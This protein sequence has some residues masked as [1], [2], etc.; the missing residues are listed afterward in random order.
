VTRDFTVV[1]DIARSGAQRF[2]G[3]I[4]LED[5]SGTRITYCDLWTRVQTRAAALRSLGLT[6]GDCVLLY[7]SSSPSWLTAFLAIVHADLVA[8]PIPAT[9]PV[10]LARLACYYASVRVALCDDSDTAGRLGIHAVLSDALDTEGVEPLETSGSDAGATAV[11]VFTSGSTARPRAVALSHANLL[12]NLRSVNEVR[13]ARDGEALL[14]ILPP[15]H[16]FELVAGQL[17]PLAAG[18]RVVYPRSLL[19]NRLLGYVRDRAIT[20]VLCVPSL[21]ELLS[22][23][24]VLMLAEE[25]LVEARCQ[26]ASAADL[27]ARF[28][29]LEATT[30]EQVR[31]AVRRLVGPAFHGLVVGGAA[32]DRPWVDLLLAAGIDVDL[33]YGLTEAGPIVSVGNARE[34]PS[35]SVGRPLPGVAVDLSPEG[36]ILVR[37]EGVMQGYLND[38]AG[39]AAAFDGTWLRTGDFGRLDADGNLYV[40]GRLK[41]AMVTANGE[42]V[43]PEEIE[44]FYSSPLFAEHC[45]VPGRGADGNDVPTL[46]VCAAD[47]G[48]SDA[49]LARA[50]ATLRAAAPPRL[51]AASFV[52]SAARL[53]RTALGKIKRRQLAD[54]LC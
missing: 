40:T 34:C 39:S 44:P 11:L 20:R 33:G 42:T 47:E 25:G 54:S 3:A 14:S 4:A 53:P 37:S 21:V 10:E 46:V 36:E 45:V 16:A 29:G 18:A 52:R 13:A 26:R 15:S 32:I 9:T 8:V 5:S 49:D 31:S 23:Q 6:P 38:A 50:F 27:W 22:R 17:A 19:P 12:A 35:G 48:C 51:R 24:V 7:M 28:E 43:Y 1:S 30:R 2:D 41:E